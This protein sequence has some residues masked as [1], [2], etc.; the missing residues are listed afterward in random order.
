VEDATDV[1]SHLAGVSWITRRMESIL[2]DAGMLWSEYPPLV[3]PGGQVMGAR[4]CGKSIIGRF[5]GACHDTLSNNLVEY[6]T[7]Y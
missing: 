6:S 5:K 7:R 1:K 2:Y 3:R 4:S